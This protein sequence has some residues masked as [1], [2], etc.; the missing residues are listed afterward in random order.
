MRYV[1]CLTLHEPDSA[2]HILMANLAHSF[3]LSI[4]RHVKYRK[5]LVFV[6]LVDC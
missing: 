5:H 2:F 3:C 1:V 4:V 6:V